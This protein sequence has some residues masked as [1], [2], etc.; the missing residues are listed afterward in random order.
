MKNKSFV[1]DTNIWI[2]LF[3]NKQELFFYNLIKENELI[4]LRSIE[5]TNELEKVLNYPKVIKKLVHHKEY[6]IDLF[7]DATH[8]IK[9]TPIFT[10]CPDPNDNYLFDLAYQS[11]ADYLVSGDKDVLNTPIV[12]PLQIISFSEFKSLINIL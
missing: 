12:E 4:I 5:L 3:Y 6:Y 1:L 11:N 9:T 8:N 10:S 2:T 7:F